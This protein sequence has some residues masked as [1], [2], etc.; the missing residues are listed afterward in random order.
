M[1]R[2]RVPGTAWASSFQALQAPFL[3]TD[4]DLL[5]RITTGPLAAAHARWT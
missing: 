3:V 2:D 5:G 1:D 4:H